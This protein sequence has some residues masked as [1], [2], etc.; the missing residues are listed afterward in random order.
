MDSGRNQHHVADSDFPLP[1]GG[2][3][4]A[5]SFQHKD[6]LILGRVNVKFVNVTGQYSVILTCTLSEQAIDSFATRPLVLPQST[7]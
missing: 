3:R 1:A 4:C 6:D 7:V 2:L 5:F